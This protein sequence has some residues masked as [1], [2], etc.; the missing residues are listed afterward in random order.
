MIQPQNIIGFK[1]KVYISYSYEIE[2]LVQKLSLDLSLSDFQIDTDQDP[3]HSPFGMGETLGI[4]YWL[5]PST[6]FSDFSYVFE[7]ESQQ[8]VQSKFADN[9]QDV[10]LW[11]AQHISTV[12]TIATG[13][14]EQDNL[15]I[16]KK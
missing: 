8:D 7:I 4:S 12:S 10:S 15:I 1:G 11:L 5:N 16:F 3:P 13:V 2:K 9:A 14:W 6:E